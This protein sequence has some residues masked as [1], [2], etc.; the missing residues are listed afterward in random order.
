MPNENTADSRI[1][2]DRIVE[3]ANLFLSLYVAIVF[4][5]LAKCI[6][7][8]IRRME[9]SPDSHILFARSCNVHQWPAIIVIGCS[10]QFCSQYGYLLCHLTMKIELFVY[11]CVCVCFLLCL[12]I[13]CV[14][15]AYLNVVHDQQS[16]VVRDRTQIYF[17]SHTII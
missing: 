13:G 12:H 9:D 15:H 14:C 2:L 4:N 5:F 11:E 6:P 8:S 1:T 3:T 7:I 16:A 10:M 17:R